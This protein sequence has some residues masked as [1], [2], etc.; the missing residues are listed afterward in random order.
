MCKVILVSLQF[1]T[2][3]N[4]PSLSGKRVAFDENGD[5]I[6]EDFTIWN[7]NDKSTAFDFHEVRHKTQETPYTF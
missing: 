6:S 4:V 2:S 5:F 1:S 3:D 7:Y